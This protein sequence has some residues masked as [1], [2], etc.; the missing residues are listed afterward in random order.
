VLVR[1][2][3]PAERRLLSLSSRISAV[4]GLSYFHPFYPQFPLHSLKSIQAEDAQAK[5][6]ENDKRMK[7]QQRRAHE[8]GFSTGSVTG[9]MAKVKD[10]LPGVAN[11]TGVEVI[12]SKWE[13]NHQSPGAEVVDVTDELAALFHPSEKVLGR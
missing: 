8:Q 9:I 12:V 3:K 1:D 5:K 13:L 2:F 11:Q 7:L 6:D 4:E 10:S